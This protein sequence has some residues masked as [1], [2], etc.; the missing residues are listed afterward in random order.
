MW[1]KAGTK[2]GFYASS[3][4]LSPLRFVSFIR[5]VKPSNTCTHYRVKSRI[6]R[7]TETS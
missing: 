6:G 2:V 4:P 1:Y 7:K 3:L 5:S